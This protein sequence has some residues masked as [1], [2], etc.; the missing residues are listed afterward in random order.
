[1]V[2]VQKGVQTIFNTQVNVTYNGNI[3]APKIDLKICMMILIVILKM[4][5][6]M[7][8]KI[9]VDLKNVRGSYYANIQG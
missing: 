9:F 3:Y 2:V 8:L 6:I 4:V 7:N 5:E 1:M